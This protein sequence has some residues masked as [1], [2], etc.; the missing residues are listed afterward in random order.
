MLE[1]QICREVWPQLA[2]I[3]LRIRLLPR[4]EVCPP[5][6]KAKKTYKRSDLRKICPK[7]VAT[8]L[9]RD[10]IPPWILQS[11][12]RIPFQR[13]AARMKKKRR[14]IL[15]ATNKYAKPL[16][17][18]PMSNSSHARSTQIKCLTRLRWSIISRTKSRVRGP[19]C[20]KTMLACNSRL[21]WKSPCSKPTTR[22]NNLLRLTTISLP[23]ALLKTTT[24]STRNSLTMIR[25]CPPLAISTI[26][27]SQHRCKW[28][29]VGAK[30][31]E[32]KFWILKSSRLPF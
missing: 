10:K 3:Q 6:L 25:R 2:V 28:S 27:R 12:F 26:N 14:P 9:T 22:I 31:R 5:G 29:W 16:T 7:T 1:A 21:A 19:W 32:V 18:H 30:V 4:D 23:V 24:T 17:T 13:R 20:I 11:K 8:P 15:E